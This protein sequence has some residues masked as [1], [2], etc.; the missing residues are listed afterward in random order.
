MQVRLHIYIL[1]CMHAGVYACIY[2]CMHSCVCG[3]LC[4]YLCMHVGKV[5]MFF[6]LCC[7]HVWKYVYMYHSGAIHFLLVFLHACMLYML[8]YIWVSSHVSG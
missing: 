4:M 3:Y 7:V 6:F 1:T 2:V 8:A 5:C